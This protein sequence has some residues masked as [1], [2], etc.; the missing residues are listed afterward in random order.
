MVLFIISTTCGKYVHNFFKELE[1]LAQF[2]LQH[3]GIYNISA[4]FSLKQQEE[5]SR[6]ISRRYNIIWSNQRRISI[7]SFLTMR[8]NA[9][10][11]RSKMSLVL[12][13]VCIRREPWQALCSFQLLL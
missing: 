2:K 11:N 7:R 1:E 3:V 9:Y 10:C 5:C 8:P 6:D 12:V 4:A 13:V